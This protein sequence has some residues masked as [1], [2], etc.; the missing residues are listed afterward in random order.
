MCSVIHKPVPF[1]PKENKGIND[2]QPVGRNHYLD[3]N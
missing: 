3:S 1:L 2:S